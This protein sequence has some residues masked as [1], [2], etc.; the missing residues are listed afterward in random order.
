M[1]VWMSRYKNWPG[2]VLHFSSST[3][4][5]K[6]GHPTDRF[7][8]NISSAAEVEEVDFAE[9]LAEEVGAEALELFYRVG[10]VEEAA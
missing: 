5:A 7:R 4:N 9:R 8:E 1:D 3:K 6:D 10:G 2:K